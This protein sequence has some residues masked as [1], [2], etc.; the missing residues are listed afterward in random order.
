VQFAR[1]LD[2]RVTDPT[3]TFRDHLR[4]VGGEIEV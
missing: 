4:A 2:T 1:Y 3:L